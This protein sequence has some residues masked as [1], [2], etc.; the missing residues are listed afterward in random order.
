[1]GL[2]LMTLVLFLSP[3]MTLRGADKWIARKDISPKE[4]YRIVLTDA[5]AD[6]EKVVAKFRLQSRGVRIVS[7]SRGNGLTFRASAH[8]NYEAL[9]KIEGVKSVADKETSIVYHLSDEFQRQCL[10]IP[11]EKKVESIDD[12]NKG[13]STLPYAFGQQDVVVPGNN[14]GQGTILIIM[15]WFSLLDAQYL[16][17]LD[18]PG[19][20]PRFHSVK[21]TVESK[22]GIG[23]GVFVTLVG[24]Y[25]GYGAATHAT[26]V[27]INI[28][29]EDEDRFD[30]AK[31]YMDLGR[32]TV[33]NLSWG[34]TTAGTDIEGKW[35]KDIAE[36]KAKNPLVSFVSAAG[37]CGTDVCSDNLFPIY[38]DPRKFLDLNVGAI[39]DGPTAYE[40][41]TA[42][43]DC[44]DIYTSDTRCVPS[45]NQFDPDEY[46][47]G[48]WVTYGTSH[49]APVVSSVL[50][51]GYSAGSVSVR[52][53]L[54]AASPAVPISLPPN[55]TERDL[56]C[57]A[58]DPNSAPNPTNP[59][60][61][62]PVQWYDT[63]MGDAGPAPFVGNED[64]LSTI[65][66]S[67]EEILLN[68]FVVCM[69]IFFIGV[70]ILVRRWRRKG[71]AAVEPEEETELIERRRSGT[72]SP[73][74]WSDDK[75]EAEVGRLV[76]TAGQRQKD[77][78]DRMKNRYAATAIFSRET[79]HNWG[80]RGRTEMIWFLKD[81]FEGSD[82]P[83]GGKLKRE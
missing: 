54:L 75:L 68:V 29:N 21:S 73:E 30:I 78:W 80:T 67:T 6:I 2:L 5:S 74:T 72:W 14:R 49:A 55:W 32:P 7:S 4:M 63:I 24:A 57:G 26:L 33:I 27:C 20:K 19:G 82:E 39:D 11:L 38:D 9:R 71:S 81:N 13:I 10:G 8:T 69:I 48:R 60:M 45:Y 1:M 28:N 23:H 66:T 15:D 22:T 36:M 50:C 35:L 44:V 51:L 64:D 37:N 16:S 34:L 76:R 31:K 46:Y 70:F 41:F 42:F 43:G 17:S 40:D 77:A 59:V 52:S 61:K 12:L 79:Y 53:D 56:D 47:N 18:R 58:F 25:E 83:V 65:P 62:V 3:D